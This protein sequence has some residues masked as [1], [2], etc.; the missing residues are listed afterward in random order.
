[1][2]G[3][4]V[5]IGVPVVPET[6]HFVA[7][8]PKFFRNSDHGERGF[9]SR[10]GSRLVYQPLL[11]EYKDWTQVDVG[12]LD[13]PEDVRPKLHVFIESKLP[14]F[15]TVDDLPRLRWEEAPNHIV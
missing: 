4:P 5:E 11:A 9:C 1:M 7:G 10:C 8:S 2:T 12:S 3:E 14:W 6:L 15:D 13:H